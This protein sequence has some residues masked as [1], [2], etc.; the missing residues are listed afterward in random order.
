MLLQ[1]VEPG[2]N[3]QPPDRS[4]TKAIGIDLGTTNSVVAISFNQKPILLKNKLGE[5]TTP[6]VVAYQ[7]EILVGEEA[8]QQALKTPDCVVSSVKRFMS[9]SFSIPMHLRDQVKLSERMPLLRVGQGRFKTPIEVS[10]DILRILKEQAESFLGHPIDQAVI[11][12]PAYFDEAARSATKEAAKMAGLSVLRLIH[13]PTAA[14]L[15]YGLDQGAEGVYAVYELGGGTFDI[16]LLKLTKGVFQVLATSGDVDLG[17]D[18][19]DQIVLNYFVEKTPG[20]YLEP[21][22]IKEALFLARKAKEYLS[23]HE[24]GVWTLPDSDHPV[25]LDR[26]I[27]ESLVGFLIEKTI[28]ICRRV[29]VDAGITPQDIEGVVLVGGATRMP[30]IRERIA[31]LFG[32]YPLINLNPDEIVAMGAALQAEALTQGSDT[33]LLDV[34]PLS[35]GL[36]TMG[37]LVEKIIPRNTPIPVTMAQEFTTYQDGQTSMKIHVV[38]GERE[39]VQHC[40]SLGECILTGIPPMIA[41]AARV[42]VTFKIDAD[43]L[44]TVVAQE[45][46]TGIQQEVQMKPSYGLSEEDLQKMLYENGANASQDLTQRLLID[47]KVVAERVISA[48]QKAIQEDADLLT[49]DDLT[50]LNQ[51][52]TLL[53]NLLTGT[54]REAIVNQQEKLEKTSYLFV[55]KR[56]NRR[57]QQALQGQKIEAK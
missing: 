46:N 1:L 20:Y 13:E 17:G 29:M 2:Q 32:K 4:Q 51:E 35:L 37:G 56:V 31:Y 43:G 27:L 50:L 38:Q 10:A 15:A 52:I 54:N 49:E 8:I 41:G 14:A 48:L 34:T 22:K 40:R 16:S 11:T 39:L 42:Q 12:V 5:T 57:L 26:L 24:V 9:Q 30:L 47:A 28:D 25:A 44:L 45:K 6:S 18:D 21:Q 33:L 36:E 55:E 3:Q 19:L 23:Y 7:E 53:T